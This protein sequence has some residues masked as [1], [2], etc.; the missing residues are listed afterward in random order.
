[1]FREVTTGFSIYIYN[2]TEA[3]LWP[4]Y[5]E[6]DSRQLMYELQDTHIDQQLGKQRYVLFTH[7]LT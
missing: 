5:F 2:E 4:L 3:I 1:M 7:E 6:L